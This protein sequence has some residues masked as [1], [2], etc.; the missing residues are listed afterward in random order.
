MTLFTLVKTSVH[1]TL[2]N[3]V[4]FHSIELAGH[5][6]GKFQLT[7]VW[8]ND[9]WQFVFRKKKKAHKLF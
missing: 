6:D 3:L 4:S 8:Q 9:M 2:S 5:R 7:L 1:L